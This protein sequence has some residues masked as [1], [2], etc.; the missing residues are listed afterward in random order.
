MYFVAM[1][2]KILSEDA[3]FLAD[4]RQY[5]VSICLLI[6]WLVILNFVGLALYNLELS[7]Q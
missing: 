7:R 2:M 4:H 6:C 5:V 3:E 1:V